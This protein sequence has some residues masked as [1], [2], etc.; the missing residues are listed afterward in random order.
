M[1]LSQNHYIIQLPSTPEAP[2]F[3]DP[4]GVAQ[5]WLNNLQTLLAIGDYAKV[6]EL[7][8]EQSWWRDMLALDWDLH[9]VQ[10]ADRIKDFLSRNQPRFQ[11]SSFRLQHQG[12]FQPKLENPR[13][14]LNWIS[15]M[16]FFESRVGNGTGFL[17][18][19]VNEA[20]QWKAYAVYTSLQE[21]KQIKEPL[22]VNRA[23]G[24]IE[25]MPGGLSK[26]NWI[27]RRK[28]Q[29]EFLDEEPATL[30]VGAG[31]AGLNTAARLQ[32]LGV[33]NLIVDKNERIGDNWRKRYRTLVT[34]D[35][36]EFTHMAYL[37]FP[38]N[39]PQFTPKDKLGDWFEAY[40]SIMELNVWLKTSIK[41]AEYDDSKS[42]WTVTLTRGDGSERVLYPRHIVWCTGHSGEPKVPT[43]VGQERFKGQFY[44]GSQ[45]RDASESDMK[46]KKV[47]VVGTGNSGHDIAQNFYENGADTTMLQR[48]GTYVITVEKGVFMMHEGLHEENGAPT[49]EADIV[50]ESLPFPVQFALAVDF[51]NR[52]RAVEK[53]TLEGL[54]KAGFK[55]DFGIDGAGISRQYI[56]RG[57]GYYID[58]GCSSL[59]IDGKIKLKHS[60]EGIS[61]F[62]ERGLILKDGSKLD[63]DIV[64]L[65]TG[66]DNM[67]TTVRKVLGDR[68]ADRLVDVWDLDEEGELNGMWRPSGHPGFWYMGGNLAICRIY[69][70]FLALQ[71][72]AIES[73]LNSQPSALKL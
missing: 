18:L 12:R 73:G 26:G 30:I 53:D 49:E 54:E 9:T 37:P 11:L 34:H 46:G 22:G 19:T 1:T 72:K 25:T 35:P 4:R 70:K 51:T 2:R 15:S 57:G 3:V 71:I 16:F 29:V 47:V 58:V 63:A 7:F 45:H 43:F 60:P 6:P 33:S 64:V 14:D 61:G 65:A 5:Q 28:R 44:H 69:S 17:R 21:L 62:D 40:A 42:Q 20:G 39:W 68:V 38:K 56:T 27:E 13:G 31:Q 8:H 66:Y 32:N 36:V 41:S 52:V 50:S 24:T 59:I 23:E 55:L 67:R 10:N 48:S